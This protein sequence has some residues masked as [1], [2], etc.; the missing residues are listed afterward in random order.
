MWVTDLPGQIRI[1]CGVNSWASRTHWLEQDVVLTRFFMLAV[2]KGSAG[3]LR[4]ESGY[5]D[6]ETYIGLGL[7]RTQ[8]SSLAQRQIVYRLFEVYMRRKREHGH[9]DPADR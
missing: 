1:W 3:A 2:I 7:R 8:T 5:L 6:K 9:Y 4:S